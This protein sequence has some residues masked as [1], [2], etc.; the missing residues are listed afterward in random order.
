[1][2]PS[3]KLKMKPIFEFPI[4]WYIILKPR[5]SNCQVFPNITHP[6]GRSHYKKNWKIW[7]KVPKGGGL[8]QTQFFVQNFLFLNHKFSFPITKNMFYSENL[9]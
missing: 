2:M 3:S 6:K 8:T 9:A 5:H 1:M 4:T 7:D